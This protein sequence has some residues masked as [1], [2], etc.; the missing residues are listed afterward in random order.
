MMAGL[1]SLRL[2]RRLFNLRWISTEIGYQV[3]HYIDLFI[4]PRMKAF[5]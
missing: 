3:M 4:S 5:S 2:E 1:P